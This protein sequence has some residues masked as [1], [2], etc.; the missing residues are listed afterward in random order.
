MIDR[1][2]SP[3]AGDE[4]QDARVL[5]L[6]GLQVSAENLR[7]LRAHGPLPA[8]ACRPRPSTPP[9]DVLRRAL[10]TAAPQ[11]EPGC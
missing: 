10:D 8:S 1:R 6:L 9:A 2:T 7:F 4:D 11:V 3:D 5:T